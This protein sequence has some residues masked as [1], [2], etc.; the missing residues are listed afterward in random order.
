MRKFLNKKVQKVF[1]NFHEDFL[2]SYRN[3]S[4]VIMFSNLVVGSIFDYRFSKLSQS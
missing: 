4:D 2:D 1:A 3:F